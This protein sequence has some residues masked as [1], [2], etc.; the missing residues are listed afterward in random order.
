MDINEKIKI[1]FN[2]NQYLNFK[3]LIKSFPTNT[4]NIFKKNQAKLQQRFFF[5]KKKFK[6]IRSRIKKR[7]YSRENIQDDLLHRK[8]FAK[9]IAE[10]IEREHQN[11][12]HT[13]LAI[14][15][16]WGSGKTWLLEEIAPMLKAKGFNVVTFNAWHYSQEKISLKRSFLQ[17][18]NKGLKSNINLDSL[19]QDTS[20]VEINLRIVIYLL[21]IILALLFLPYIL[22]V[23]N[24]THSFE[25]QKFGETFIKKLLNSWEW[26]Y[27]EWLSPFVFIKIGL[28]ATL[29]VPFLAALS[30]F[31]TFEKSNAKI[32]EA[33]E[34]KNKFDNIINP[35]R[36]WRITRKK[37]VA[38]FVDDL[39]RCTPD[40][41]KQVLDAL[42]TF[43]EHENCSFVVTGDHTVIERYVGN[44]LFLEPKYDGNGIENKNSLANLQRHEGRRFLKKI[45]NVYWQL[46]QPDPNT[47]KYFVSKKIKESE[48]PFNEEQQ[49]QLTDLMTAFLDKNLREVIRF[50]DALVF[51][52]NT[53]KNMIA[54]KEI[55]ISKLELDRVEKKLTESEI[56]NLKTVQSQ[57][58]LLAKT[59][60][61]QELFYPIYEEHVQNHTDILLQEKALRNTQKLDTLFKRSITMFFFDDYSKQKYIE[62]IKI[63]PQFTD[64]NNTTI[65]DPDTFWYLSGVTGLPSNR[66]PDSDKFLQFIKIP[67]GYTE[68]EKALTEASLDTKKRLLELT[69]EYLETVTDLNEKTNGI[70]NSLK[71]ALKVFSWSGITNWIL[72]LIKEEEFIYSIEPDLK[73]NILIDIFTLCFKHNSQLLTVFEDEV[74]STPDYNEYKWLALAQ[75]D[76]YI[77]S[78]LVARLS[79]LIEDDLDLEEDISLEDLFENLTSLSKKVNSKDST[80]KTIII[81]LLKKIIDF[82]YS[83]KNSIETFKTIISQI[84]KIDNNKELSHYINQKENNALNTDPWLNSSSRLEFFTTDVSDYYGVDN[85]RNYID[86][87][88]SKTMELE[89]ETWLP[90]IKGLIEKDMVSDIY[91]ENI[92][93]KIVSLITSSENSIKQSTS[94]FLKDIY[95]N[96]PL[97]QF[98]ILSI[99]NSIKNENDFNIVFNILYIVDDFAEKLRKHR[100]EQNIIKKYLNTENGDVNR[101]ANSILHQLNLS[102]K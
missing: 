83:N 71:L 14:S 79:S 82:A 38:I 94:Q 15:A 58:A 3:K 85:V 81:D 39:D 76:E 8:V 20:S 40:A 87:F 6:K 70:T 74:F 55:V 12:R 16:K 41:V 65:F 95:G 99:V 18:L 43:F 77:H 97:Q 69:K 88:I 30:K 45:F 75:Q 19:Y 47:F 61:I 21:V 52:M 29:T 28:T 93:N 1:L 36:F 59:L 31:L 34:F 32:T 91:K 2:N 44:S 37:R 86:T 35:K 89:I 7:S 100:S 49:K 64:D 27:N 62:L 25:Y 24:Q 56:K 4:S 51:T 42:T 17:T 23:I 46:P 102:K 9:E 68:I 63:A 48:F 22:D 78:D 11:G 98:H 10:K 67:D 57:P 54:E 92:T 72:Q 13:I 96:L 26:F 53:L 5:L 66:G 73:E 90:I 60:L 101:F 50:I 80:A 33:D 84:A